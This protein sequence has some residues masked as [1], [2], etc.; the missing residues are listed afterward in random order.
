MA[1][2]A[3]ES[4]KSADPVHTSTNAG[5]YSVATNAG[6][7]SFAICTGISC[8]AKGALGCYIA[9]AEWELKEGERIL[10]CFKTHKVDGRTIKTDVFYTLKNGKFVVAENIEEADE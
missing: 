3:A 9:L 1:D 10:K 5:D 8:K 6:K 2:L 4:L 7:S